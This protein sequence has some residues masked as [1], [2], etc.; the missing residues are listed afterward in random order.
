LFAAPDHRMV[1]KIENIMLMPQHKEK[2]RNM[3]I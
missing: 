3:Q 1:L 2:N